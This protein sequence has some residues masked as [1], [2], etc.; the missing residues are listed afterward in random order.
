MGQIGQ[1]NGHA[2]SFADA[3]RFQKIRNPVGRI[4]DLGI[5][6]G[7]IVEDRIDLIRVTAGRFIRTANSGFSYPEI[8]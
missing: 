1:K 3:A 6:A 8:S 7:G 4:F 5:G 2:V